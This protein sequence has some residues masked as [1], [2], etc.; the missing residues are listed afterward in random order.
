MIRFK[1]CR[2]CGWSDVEASFTLSWCDEC[3]K[4]AT[5]GFVSAVAAGVGAYL[6]K[7]VLA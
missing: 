1:E 7:L 5:K 4:A 6:L 3:A 2:N